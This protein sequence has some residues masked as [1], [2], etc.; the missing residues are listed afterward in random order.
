VRTIDYRSIR[1]NAA[2]CPTRRAATAAREAAD[3]TFRVYDGDQLITEVA[4]TTTK[5]ITDSS[6]ESPKGPDLRHD[7]PVTEELVLLNPWS[8]LRGDRRP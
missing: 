1:L 7:D 4:R 3:T 6:S 5:P 2:K 8:D